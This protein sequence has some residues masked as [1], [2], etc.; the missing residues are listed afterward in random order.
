MTHLR[1]S[2][3]LSGILLHP[4][5]LAGPFG[6]GD[7]GPGARR[8]VDLMAAADQ[9]LWQ[10]LPLNTV[11]EPWFLPYLALSPSRAIHS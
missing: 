5:S 1:A 11:Y 6:V 3:R 10:V 4:T 2:P 9:R 7:F 8:F